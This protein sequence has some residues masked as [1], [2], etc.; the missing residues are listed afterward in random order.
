[1]QATSGKPAASVSDTPSG[2]G[3]S[4]PAGTTTFSA[5]PPPLSSAQTCVKQ[6]HGNQSEHQQQQQKQ[7][8]IH[9]RSS[10]WVQFHFTLSPT[11]QREGAL[12]PSARMV[13]EHSSPG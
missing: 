3:S 7:T 10:W 13:P 5:Y 4:C 2:I 11:A 12:G 8:P 6:K 9:R 1:V